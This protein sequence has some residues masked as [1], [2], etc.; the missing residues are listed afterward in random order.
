MGR[1]GP[2]G[3]SVLSWTHR[4][5][6]FLGDRARGARPRL[7]CRRQS[8]GPLFFDTYQRRVVGP[9]RLVRRAGG[10]ATSSHVRAGGRVG[11]RS[12]AGHT[13]ACGRRG[14]GSP[15][16][17]RVKPAGLSGWAT[18]DPPKATLL[19]VHVLF[20]RRTCPQLSPP[21]PPKFDRLLQST[22]FFCRS[23]TQIP[24]SCRI[25]KV[26]GTKLMCTE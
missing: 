1:L 6:I 19:P 13:R 16:V 12:Q 18:G 8:Q 4:V 26:M 17:F 3:Q 14:F 22:V 15:G 20:V 25:N 7:Q 11:R 21:P 23:M 24:L 9:A 5:R 10:K 2:A